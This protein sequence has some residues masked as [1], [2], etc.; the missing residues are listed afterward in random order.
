MRSDF[1][2]QMKVSKILRVV[3]HL[4]SEVLL[5][6]RLFALLLA[7]LGMRAPIPYVQDTILNLRHPYIVVTTDMLLLNCNQYF[8]CHLALHTIRVDTHHLLVP[9]WYPL[10][11]AEGSGN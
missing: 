6:Y 2:T 5:V 7:R 10:S 11:C 3:L 8:L 4:D 9:G 1:L